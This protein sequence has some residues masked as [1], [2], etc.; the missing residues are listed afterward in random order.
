[1]PRRVD[2]SREAFWRKVVARQRGSGLSVK[3]FCQQEGVAVASF[4]YWKRRIREQGS[5]PQPA[6]QF[7]PVRVVAQEPARSET[8]GVIEI[9]LSRARRIRLRGPV[10][11][12][13]LATVV[14]V[15]EA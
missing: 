9:R 2:S 10:D 15:L 11:S 1:M 12:Q 4:F 8:G 14:A 13:Q 6:V 3:G 7:A 5:D